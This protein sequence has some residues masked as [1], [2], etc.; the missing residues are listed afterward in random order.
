MPKA[1]Q[2]LFSILGSVFSYLDLKEKNKYFDE[3]SK[4]KKEIENEW[5]KPVYTRRMDYIDRAELRLFDLVSQI[6]SRID[7]KD[8]LN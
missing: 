3:Y 5:S 1:V 7:K 4:L 6:S 2:A 8:S